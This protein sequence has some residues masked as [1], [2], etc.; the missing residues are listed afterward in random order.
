MEENLNNNKP[1]EE[2]TRSQEDWQAELDS[3][4]NENEDIKSQLEEMKKS[5]AE[6]K[7]MNFT[8]ARQINQGSKVTGDEFL[9][10]LMEV[11]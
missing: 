4:K 8:L 7:E 6:T 10:S 9:K 5:L 1:E 2:Q 3:Y 11:L